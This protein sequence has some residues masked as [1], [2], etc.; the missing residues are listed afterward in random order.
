MEATPLSGTDGAF[1]PAIS[2]DGA[3]IGFLVAGSIRRIPAQGG[4]VT[5]IADSSISGPVWLDDRTVAYTDQAFRARTMPV[6]GG[7]SRALFAPRGDQAALVLQALPDGRG[8]LLLVCSANATCAPTQEIWVM[9][10]R[11]GEAKRL[12]SDVGWAGYA[13]GR[14]LFARKDGEMFAVPFDLGT[15][16]MQ[17]TPVP[18][19][20]GVNLTFWSG[21]RPSLSASGSLLYLTG[22]RQDGRLEA[23]WVSRDGRAV[24]VDTAWDFTPSTWGTWALSP[25]GRRL[26]ISLSTAGNPDIWI[27]ELDRGPVS[28]LTFSDSM[29]LRPRWTPDGRS[30]T[31][32]SNRA[33]SWQLFSRRADGIG[34]DSLVLALPAP[35]WEATWSRDGQWLVVRV[36]GTYGAQVIQKDLAVLRAG[37]DTVPRPL[38]HA[39]YDELTPAL[40]PDGRWL[41]YVSDETGRREVF[42]RPFPEVDSGKWQVSVNGGVNPVWA[43]SGGE[44]FFIDERLDLVSQ[45]VPS[46]AVFQGGQQRVLFNVAGYMRDP[47]FSSFDLSTD[48]QR[49]LMVRSK[50]LSTGDAPPMVIVVENWLEEVRAKMKK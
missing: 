16:S 17:G 22:T 37:R 8:V 5:T 13:D 34:A 39:E 24:P 46:G 32:H 30:V 7:E 3:W 38:L 28:R 35:I 33:G 31:F 20:G 23:V 50:A 42:V 47:D 27:K 21:P 44:L 45:S 19:S 43:H 14:L 36:G 6:A 40:S 2:P 15:L 10:G 49:F 9:D 12:M 41:A 29:D 26:A 4:T 48:D 25:D 18:L 1:A 11:T